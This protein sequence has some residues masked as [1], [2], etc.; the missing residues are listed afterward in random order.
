M[1][2]LKSPLLHFAP[3][4]IN[5]VALGQNPK[6]PTKLSQT[7]FNPKTGKKKRIRKKVYQLEGGDLYYL[8]P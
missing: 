3:R 6:K 1:N 5:A 7:Y 4:Q 8:L 2:Q